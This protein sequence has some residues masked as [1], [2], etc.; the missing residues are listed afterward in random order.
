MPGLRSRSGGEV[1]LVVTGSWPAG[2]VG[3]KVASEVVSCSLFLGVRLQVGGAGR[4]PL[5]GGAPSLSPK[6]SK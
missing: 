1:E 4:L 5:R 3:T 2:G 6:C